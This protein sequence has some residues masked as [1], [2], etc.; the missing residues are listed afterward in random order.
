[1]IAHF[2]N[3][4]KSM[5]SLIDA[6]KTLLPQVVVEEAIEMV[7]YNEFGVGFEIICQQL[8]EYNIKISP[9]I[10]KQIFVIGKSMEMKEN[11]W[12]FLEELV[13]YD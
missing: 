11:D 7:D 4:W 1:M 3:L 10:Y 5:L 9:D 8:F 2:E 13:R 6:V 12:N